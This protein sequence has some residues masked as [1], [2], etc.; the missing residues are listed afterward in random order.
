[1]ANKKAI[2]TVQIGGWAEIYEE[3]V[4]Q[5]RKQQFWVRQLKRSVRGIKAKMDAGEPVPTW[6]QIERRR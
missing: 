3:A 5:L 4:G 1:M 2:K 6:L